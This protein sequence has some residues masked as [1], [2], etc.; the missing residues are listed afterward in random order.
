MKLKIV[1]HEAEEGGYWAEAPAIPGCCSQGETY[2]QVL[3]NIREAAEGCLT[4]GSGSIHLG[5]RDR[6]VEISI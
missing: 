5:E 3:E 1:I 2:E 6:I 4:C